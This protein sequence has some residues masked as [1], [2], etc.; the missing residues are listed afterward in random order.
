MQF[1]GMPTEI[2][3]LLVHSLSG[4]VQFCVDNGVVPGIS[5]QPESGIRQGDPLSPPIFALLTIFL[6]FQFRKRCPEAQL[7]LY[8]DDLL[9][10]IPGGDEEALKQAERAMSLLNEFGKFSGLH[11]NPSKSFAVLKRVCGPL[12]KHYVGLEVRERVKYLGVLIG[13]VNAEQAY[14]GPMAKMKSRA[15]F[16]KTLPLDLWERAE[17][18]KVWVQPV[19]QLTARVY[20]P[21]QKVLTTLNVIFK[22][23][24]GISTWDLIPAMLALPYNQGGVWTYP[25]AVW[26]RFQYGR[27]FQSVLKDKVCF[28]GQWVAN[29]EQWAESIGMSL[30]PSFLPYLQL[31]VVKMSARTW[32]QASV[33]M[34]SRLRQ[35]AAAPPLV[36]IPSNMPL[37]HNVL[38]RNKLGHTYYS[39]SL[40]RKGIS[41][42]A[43]IVEGG[44]LQAAVKLPPTWTPVY[45]TKIPQVLA[46]P[47][48]DLPKEWTQPNQKML[49]VL[50]LLEPPQKRQEPEVWEQLALLKLP[51]AQRDFMRRAL[52]KKLAVGART[53]HAY[54]QP[55]CILCSVPKTIKHVL[56]ACKF[57]PV[58]VDIVRKA[59]GPVWG[60]DG[61]MC[62]M[63]TLLVAQPL[64]SLSTT[65]GLALWAAA[66]ASWVLRCDAK[67]R[68]LSVAMPDFVV[69]WM[70]LV[71]VWASAPQSSF[72]RQEAKHLCNCLRK[73]LDGDQPFP[74]MQPQGAIVR[75]RGVQVPKKEKWASVLP[76]LLQRID[77]KAQQGWDVA[78]VDGSKQETGG[79]HHAGYG[80]WFGDN[81]ARNEELP[82]LNTERQ[83]ITRAELRAALRAVYHKCPGRPL[84]VVTDSELVY[85]GLT[86]KCNK[87][88]RHKWV[89]SRGPLAHVDLW[90][91]LWGQW[92]L[93]GD[94]VDV[95]WVPSHVGV[96]GNEHAD[97]KASKGARKA[98]EC[99]MKQKSV[100]DIWGELGLQ[101]MPDS[102]DTES[103]C[104]G[105]SHISEELNEDNSEN[106][107][108][109]CRY[110]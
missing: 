30:G 11:V 21:S 96:T 104:S 50:C 90:E 82:L 49:A 14:A 17:I 52:W 45:R 40:V 61:A 68:S 35:R 10:W 73:F 72:V 70:T 41:T 42:L 55:N 62:P 95:L 28:S 80:V 4:Q 16:L 76:G 38:F 25:L 48:Q 69:A 18:Y 12:P 32:L 27:L 8:A 83:S 81:D 37:W 39:P 98:Y 63:D 7:M 77:A 34:F 107:P 22:I 54:H 106:W 47:V 88:S 78:F 13:Q 92:Q 64:L 57:W 51:G 59:F 58:A 44:E 15:T 89:G 91:D 75:G 19:V 46:L 24:L 3:E 109:R 36:G 20:E 105:G 9:I 29:F 60:R 85:K 94:S 23:A 110:S 5:M 6:V 79:V 86:G 93:L 66:R 26:V 43:Q 71:E 1:L 53:Q 101:E 31:A 67:F 99:V 65:Q 102:Y 103:N 100:Q 2:T 33:L 56:T 87:W 84:L 97:A 108:K 74:S